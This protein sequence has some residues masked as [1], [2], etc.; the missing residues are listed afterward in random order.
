MT[1]EV[2]DVRL[3]TVFPTGGYTED[4]ERYP[5]QSNYWDPLNFDDPETRLPATDRLEVYHPSGPYLYRRVL[6]PV[7][8]EGTVIP[9]WLY[10]TGECWNDHFKEL[11][12]RVWRYFS[13][14]EIPA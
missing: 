13:L 9:A 1:D 11:S 2:G 12:G 10:M 8:A 14:M 3:I 6:V 4:L 7:Q 5:E